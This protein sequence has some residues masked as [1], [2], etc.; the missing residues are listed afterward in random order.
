[1]YLLFTRS[2]GEIIR[3]KHLASIAS[4]T[5]SSKYLSD[6]GVYIDPEDFFLML[7]SRSGAQL[8]ILLGRE[9]FFWPPPLNIFLR[10]GGKPS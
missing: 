6:L 2:H 10:G 9:H 4:K 7:F 3:I 8:G 5:V 1:M